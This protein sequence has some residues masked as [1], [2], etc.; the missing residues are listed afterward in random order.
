[1]ETA[2]STRLSRARAPHTFFYSRDD[3]FA[4]SR[5]RV[6]IRRGAVGL[7]PSYKSGPGLE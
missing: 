6:P 3:D 1:M 7:W 2:E 4:A 5:I